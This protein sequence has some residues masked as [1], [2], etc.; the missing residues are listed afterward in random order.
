MAY[1]LGQKMQRI[2]KSKQVLCITHLPQVA[3]FTSHHLY[4]SKYIENKD[5]KTRVSLLNE[6]QRIEEIAKM[7]SGD[8]VS[9]QA[10]QQAQNLI[11]QV[12]NS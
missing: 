1:A 3:A 4:I 6:N 7:L 5:T 8:L 9:E 12:N 11:E 2:A 10:L